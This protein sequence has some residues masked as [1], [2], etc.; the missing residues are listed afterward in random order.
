MIS[1]VFIRRPVTASVLSILIVLAGLLALRSLPIQQ[2]P[3]IVPPQ[4]VASAT[5]SGATAQTAS[6]TVAA[7]L[8][9]YINGVDNMLYM[10]S[11]ADDSGAV[12][13]RVVFEVGTDIDQAAIDVDSAV[14]RA[15]S[16]LPEEVQ[17]AGV[18]INKESAAILKIVAITSPDGSRDSLYLNNYATLTVQDELS[19]INGVASATFFGSK[20]YAMRI[21]LRP[22]QLANYGMV[23]ADVSSAI[24]EQNSMFSAGRF[25]DSPN[26]EN[27]QE[28]SIPIETEGRFSSPEQ[29]ENIILRANADGSVVRL[30]DVAR[31]EL[32]ASNYNFDAIQNGETVV[33]IGITL[34]PGANA[35]E[36]SQAVDEVMER[37]SRNFPSGVGYNIAFDTT[38]FVQV[39]IQQVVITL[40]QA[41]VLVVA[42]IYLFL[43]R[44]RATLIP[45]MAIPVALIGAFA[46]MF[47][48]G[49]SINLLT[50]L[51]I[52]LSIGIVVDDAI[53]V[54]ENVER[55]MR[56]K[57]LTAKQAAQEAM[58][59]VSGPIITMVLVL[60]SVFI[61]VAFLGGLA[62]VMYQQFALTIAV[63]VVLSGLVGLTLSPALCAQILK[64]EAETPPKLLQKFN[65]FFDYAT[66]KY[67]DGVRF[68]LKRSGLAFAIF[69]VLSLLA[70]TIF[71][72]LPGGLVPDEDQGYIL[73]SHQLSEGASLERTTEFS[74]E[75]NEILR[76]EDIVE[77]ALT[78][79]GYDMVNGN[80]RANVGASFLTLKSW[81]DRN[82][83]RES[84][85]QFAQ[86]INQIGEDYPQAIVSA[87]NPPPI[88]GISTTGGIEAYL[89]VTMEGDTEELI[90]QVE[91][92][93]NSANLRPELQGVRTTLNADV[94][95]YRTI[96]DRERAKSMGVNLN[97]VFSAMNRVFGRSYVNDFNYL[98]RAWRVYM[99]G[100]SSY[101]AGPEDLATTFVRSN[102]GDM[103]PLNSIV[104]LERTTGPDTVHRYNNRPAARIIGEPAPGYSTGQAIAAMEEVAN[105]LFDPQSG[106]QLFWTGASQQEQASGGAGGAAFMFGILIVFLLL[107]AQY[108]RWTLPLVVLTA[109]PFAAFGAV[110]AVWMAGMQNNIYFQVGM[111]VLIGLAAKNAILITEFA[112]LNRERGMSVREAALEAC[113]QRFRPILMTS[114]AFILGS[115][116][117]AISS[118]AGAAARN[119]VGVTVVGGMLVATFVSIFF[120][121]VFY[122]FIERKFGRKPTKGHNI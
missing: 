83:R 66:R 63:S 116:P 120:I 31:V 54:L 68:M 5:Y 72:Q 107:A 75:W 122:Q 15:M 89:V 20:T 97:D 51:A 50:L 4:V 9:L 70:Y 108:E 104:R 102:D 36:V 111:L 82:L 22:D 18:R 73:V 118:G 55:L 79:I 60:V 19:R 56:E 58:T 77:S 95:R 52:V 65:R 110:L 16:R 37:M 46:G 35:L 33:P 115:V 49:F 12:S 45:L 101:R 113:R 74:I 121:P 57:G 78:F 38:D 43:Q 30:S 119:A 11:S 2:Y 100:E 109:I 6:D 24:N 92:L 44:L 48:F 71:S 14:Q 13:I 3:Q 103:V 93:S 81:D 59:E 61:P 26:P 17:R 53:V 8:E 69:G 25:G 114:L 29:F 1:H 105:N 47:V 96:I 27:P 76:N 34:R 88:S 10:T 64:N 41:L 86:H 90:N 99:S 98:G 42:V 62:G 112:V 23:P 39:S 87:F 28:L 40:I 84:S 32:G 85:Q 117:L 91:R 21:W 80:T 106:Y 67:T 94:P 7:P